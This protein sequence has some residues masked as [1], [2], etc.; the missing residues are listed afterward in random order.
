M[1]N[2]K[3]VNNRKFKAQEVNQNDD[4][5]TMRE[6]IYRRFSR[7][8]KRK[9]NLPDLIIIDG[10]KGQLSSAYKILCDFNLEKQINIIGLAKR[11]EEVFLP[12]ISESIMLPKTSSSLKLIQ[13]L[14][15]EA[16]RFAITFHK[17]LRSKRITS[18]ELDNIKGIGPVTKQKLLSHF[19]SIKN[20]R[21]ATDEEISKILN[22][23]EFE[24]LK[25]FFSTNTEN[26]K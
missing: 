9:T 25:F 19:G 13:Q 7:C 18:S 10:G 6:T 23:K 11:L 12:N 24:A 5:A 15:D 20:L 17:Q 4:F 21:G 3:K 1:G 8:H 2:L 22:I 16:H 14:R 26:N